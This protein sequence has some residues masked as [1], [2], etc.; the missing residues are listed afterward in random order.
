MSTKI[1]PGKFDCYAKLAR[2]EPY[3]VL[4]AKDPIAPDMVRAWRYIRCGDVAAAMA[5]LLS[6]HSTWEHAVDNEDRSMLHA[7][8]DKSLEALSCSNAMLSWRATHCEHG[9]GLTDYCLPCGRITSA[10]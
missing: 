2:D 1:N 10:C 7:G 6:A 8:S 9:R 5:E 4:R 3:F